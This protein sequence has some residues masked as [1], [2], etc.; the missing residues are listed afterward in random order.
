M[1]AEERLKL[2]HTLPDSAY[3]SVAVAALHDGVGEKTIRRNYPLIKISERRY[4]VSVGYLR[5]RDHAS[6][7]A[8][9]RKSITAA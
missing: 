5:H 9:D 6:A 8:K 7:P 2:I 4:G 1:S 3:V